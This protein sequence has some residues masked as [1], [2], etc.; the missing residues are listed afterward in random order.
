[1]RKSKT[2]SK[3]KTKENIKR[4]V[5]KLTRSGR[6]GIKFSYIPNR[7]TKELITYADR[8]R[9]KANSISK[10]KSRTRK[11][12]LKIKSPKLKSRKTGMRLTQ[13]ISL[14][15][16][17]TR[18]IVPNRARNTGG[19]NELPPELLT[20]IMS[21][22]HGNDLASTA[23]VSSLW[24]NLSREALQSP[25]K[26]IIVPLKQALKMQKKY[27]NAKI[28][29]IVTAEEYEDPYDGFRIQ[30]KYYKKFHEF[31]FYDNFNPRENPV[32]QEG[33]FHQTFDRVIGTEKVAGKKMAR[34]R[35]YTQA[36]ME[37]LDDETIRSMGF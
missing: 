14:S 13:R 26:E 34:V 4:S 1:M 32:K 5:R 25:G 10:L 8:L 23:Q 9:T 12:I 3:S 29:P 21:N 37:K 28:V 22:L 36:E 11:S 24:D 18:P 31:L 15:K 16:R 7:T 20:H 17:G 27:P 19:I 33:Y 35:H 2:K 30:P 6:A